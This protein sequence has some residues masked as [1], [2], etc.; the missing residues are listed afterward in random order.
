MY[1]TNATLDVL[2]AGA[3]KST[4]RRRHQGKGNGRPLVNPD[5]AVLQVPQ[6]LIKE[7]GMFAAK[8]TGDGKTGCKSAPDILIENV[9]NLFEKLFL[10]F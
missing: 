7:F 4:P 3:R 6:R 9:P 2:Q 1:E 8:R 5:C 10:I